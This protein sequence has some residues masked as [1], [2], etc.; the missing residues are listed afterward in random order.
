[1]NDFEDNTP[2]KKCI[3]IFKNG[4][5]EHGKTLYVEPHWTFQDLLNASSQRLNLGSI[6]TRMFTVDGVDIDDCMMLED[7][8][9]VFLAE[10]HD[11]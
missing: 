6:A 5:F 11:Q 2:H 1:M 4:D 3:N 10:H 7:S 8:D 9:I